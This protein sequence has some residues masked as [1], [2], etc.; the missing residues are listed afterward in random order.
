MK[1]AVFFTFAALLALTLGFA[2]MVFVLLFLAAIMCVA[3]VEDK[4]QQDEFNATIERMNAE[5]EDI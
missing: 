4:R 3:A 5:R 2:P 1:Y